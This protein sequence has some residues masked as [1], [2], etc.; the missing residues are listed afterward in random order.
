MHWKTNKLKDICAT[1]ADGDWIESKDQSP[2]GIRLLQ[3]GNIGEAVFKERNEK[4]RYISA[5]T[6]DRLKCT[7]VLP[8]DCLISRLPD[9]VGRACVVPSINEKMITGVDCTIVRFK[10]EV[11]SRWFV[12]Y[13]LSQAYYEQV[14]N[15]V[16]GATRQR[17]SRTNLGDV[18]VPVPPIYEQKRILAVLDKAFSAI[19]KA[20]E[21]TEKNLANVR[22]LFASYLQKVFCKNRAEW[23]EVEL[24]SILE[25]TETVNPAKDPNKKFLYID[26]S[27]VNKDTLTIENATQISG[28]DA[29]SRARKLIKTND[30]IF[31]TVRPTLH[32]IA[33][34]TAE[35]DEQ[36]CSTGYF[37]LRGK[38]SI[39]HKLL[40]YFLQTNIF[41]ERMEKLQK[42][43]SYPAV[44]DT[45]VK[46]QIIRFPKTVPE[47]NKVVEA[48][49]NLYEQ[50]KRLGA[51][52]EKKLLS[53]E[54][55]KRSI[56]QKAFSGTLVGA[57]S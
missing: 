20:K 5:A 38:A 35:Y 14:K 36:V 12:Y 48:L 33:I 57:K 42:G 29:P 55:L 9:P 22:E 32:R 1:F 6:F 27:S 11:S 51:A 49:D 46:S 23:E 47:Q 19:D 43:S 24:G 34:V 26:V 10:P 53:L 16:G 44:T 15:S 28:K 18:L 31:A 7:E 45:D 39:N 40:F 2:A 56:L 30:V 13:S 4:A 21:N 8:Q 52:Y 50:T 17:I 37:V 3:T 41:S 25:K 54:E